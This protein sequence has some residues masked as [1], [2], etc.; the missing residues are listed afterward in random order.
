MLL[1]LHVQNLLIIDNLDVSFK[2]GFTVITGE[3]GSGKSVILTCLSL[4]LGDKGASANLIKSGQ[5]KASVSCVFQIK[6]EFLR[7]KFFSLGLLEKTED[8]V[9]I[10]KII[11]KSGSRSFINDSPVTVNLLN[12][13]S[14]YFLEI[15]SQFENSTLFFAKNYIDILDNFAK[16]KNKISIPII[17]ILAL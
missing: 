16:I 12:E 3:T 4:A 2:D 5:D 11:T 9:I 6:N 7:E 15:N 13:I 14:P 1:Q 8:I 17:I 10:K